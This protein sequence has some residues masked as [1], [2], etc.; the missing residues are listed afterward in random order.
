MTVT[1]PTTS[2]RTLVLTETVDRLSTATSP[3]QVTEIVAAAVRALTGADGATFVLREDDQC[4]YADENA[5]TPLW[6]GSRFPLTACVSGWS[7]LHRQTVVIADIYD[8]DRVPHDAYRPTFV[9]SLCMAPI[10]SSDP[11]GA[12]GAYWAESHV[13]EPEVVRHLEVLANSTAVALENL[14]LRGAIARRSAERDQEAAR[15]DEL[16]AAMHSLVHDLRGPLGA[17]MGFSELVADGTA[18]DVTSAAAYAHSALGA[19]QRMSDQ[20]DRMLSIY[21]LSTEPLHIEP[22]DLSAV[23]EGIAADLR[24]Q[25]RARNATIEIEPAIRVAADPALVHLLLSNLF[26][27]A[28]KYTSTSDEAAIR[29]RSLGSDGAFHTLEVSDN[30]VGFDAPEPDSVFRP[31]TRLHSAEEFPG[32]GLGLASVARIVALHGGAVSARGEKGIGAAFTFSL[33]AAS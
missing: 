14:E 6:K 20:I 26:D 15:A 16:D 24:V 5:I 21:R 28:V 27:N 13:P 19:G 32:T 22:L 2:A 17:M 23:A 31:L 10:R 4:F 9:S 29:L 11:I 33:P 30:G 18:T 12:L 7:M 25:G 1:E 8:D 3:A